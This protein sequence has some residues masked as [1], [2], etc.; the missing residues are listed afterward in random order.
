MLQQSSAMSRLRALYAFFAT[1]SSSLHFTSLHPRTQDA[2]PATK[3]WQTSPTCT[4]STVRAQAVDNLPPPRLR[5]LSS[6]THLTQPLLCSSRLITVAQHMALAV[7]GILRQRLWYLCD[8]SLAASSWT[9][10]LRKQRLQLHPFRCELE[11]PLLNERRCFAGLEL[12]FDTH[13]C[14][15]SIRF[16]CASFPPGYFCR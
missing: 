12:A 7:A 5:L 15:L 13:A 16:V 6:T 11:G 9:A 4:P 14:F 8:I 3:Q 1:P 2:A 10:H